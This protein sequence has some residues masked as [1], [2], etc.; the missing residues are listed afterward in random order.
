LIPEATL[1]QRLRGRKPH[2]RCANP[3]RVPPLHRLAERLESVLAV[4]YV[5]FNEGYAA[6]AGDS[7]VRNDIA[8]DAI[9]LGRMLHELLPKEPE[10]LGL[11]ALMLLHDSRRDARVNCRGELVPLEEQDRS[12]WRRDQIEEGLRSWTRPCGRHPGRQVQAAIAA[13][14]AHAETASLTDW[15]EIT[16]LRHAARSHPRWWSRST[17]PWRSQ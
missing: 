5:I 12:L 17:M 3:L 14:H 15:E 11:L 2:P 1:A 9:R 13:T 16:A 4:I 10:P 6:T 8:A 7:L